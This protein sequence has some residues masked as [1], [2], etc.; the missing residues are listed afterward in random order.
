MEHADTSQFGPVQLWST[1][2]GGS[3]RI[4]QEH[5]CA[6]LLCVRVYLSAGELVVPSQ[7][8]GMSKDFMDQAAAR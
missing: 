3:F 2:S 4:V 8:A 7:S 5:R 1:Q 6:R